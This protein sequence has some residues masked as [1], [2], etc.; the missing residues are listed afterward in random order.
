MATPVRFGPAISAPA[1]QAGVRPS[2]GAGFASK[3]API[4]AALAAGAQTLGRSVV[5]AATA[6]LPPVVQNLAQ[7]AAGALVG[8]LAGP[9]R[10]KLAL[11]DAAH[12]LLLV[13]AFF[14]AS[15]T[16]QIERD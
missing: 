15:N 11:I 8:E 14:D 1:F 9:D 4:G 10:E 7:N 12:Q 2:S 13:N 5:Q 3:L 16:P 6:G